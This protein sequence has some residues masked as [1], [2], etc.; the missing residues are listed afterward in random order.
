MNTTIGDHVEI[1]L[2]RLQGLAKSAEAKL[3]QGWRGFRFRRTEGSGP[4]KRPEVTLSVYDPQGSR[5]TVFVWDFFLN[6]NELGYTY[7][8][9]GRSACPISVPDEVMIAAW[10]FVEEVESLRHKAGA[11]SV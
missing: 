2:K 4:C 1:L 11:V 10:A 5:R 6:D 3:P 8:A 7:L 9:A